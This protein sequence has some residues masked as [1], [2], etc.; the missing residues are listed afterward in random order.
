MELNLGDPYHELWEMPVDDLET[1]VDE[2]AT[3]QA[4]GYLDL[5]TSAGVEY[6]K[7]MIDKYLQ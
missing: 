2:L 1:M 4:E 5:E 6:L 3:L 7:A